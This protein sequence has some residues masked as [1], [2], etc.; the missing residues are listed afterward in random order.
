MLLLVQ[1]GEIIVI[2]L[3]ALFPSMSAKAV[4]II[5]INQGFFS[6]PTPSGPVPLKCYCGKTSNRSLSKFFNTL[7]IP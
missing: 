1:D 7:G 6:F 3:H 2:H 4:K 5:N